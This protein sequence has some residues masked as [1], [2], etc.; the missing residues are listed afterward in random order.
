MT[1]VSVPC[2]VRC[3]LMAKDGEKI[4]A[5]WK[6]ILDHRP[7]DIVEHRA[8]AALHYVELCSEARKGVET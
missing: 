3:L 6:R 8:R 7:E 5:R 4:I 1:G 2:L